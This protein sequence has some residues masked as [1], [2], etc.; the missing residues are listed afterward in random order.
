[1]HHF[2]KAAIEFLREIIGWAL[3]IAALIII[4]RMP[5]VDAQ[6]DEPEVKYCQD[7]T[8]GEVAV[9]EEG[10]PCPYPMAEM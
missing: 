4:M 1:M 2:K 3:V 8:T 9:V 7:L 10:A 6:E 5:V